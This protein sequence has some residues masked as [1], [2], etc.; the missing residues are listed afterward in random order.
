[1][2]PTL[3]TRIGRL[4]RNRIFKL[5]RMITSFHNTESELPLIF[6]ILAGALLTL[7]RRLYL[8]AL[9]SSHWSSG[10]IASEP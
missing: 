7:E 8:P 6:N 3:H 5:D 9:T 10:H 1:M 2:R 4:F